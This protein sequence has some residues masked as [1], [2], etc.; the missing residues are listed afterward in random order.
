MDDFSSFSSSPPG[1]GILPEDY[2]G[3][4]VAHGDLDGD[5][6]MNAHE[7]EKRLGASDSFRKAVFAALEADG[8]IQPSQLKQDGKKASVAAMLE[9]CAEPVVATAKHAHSPAVLRPKG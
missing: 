7:F 8:A 3:I 6:M 1:R 2:D 4:G 9:V 5:G